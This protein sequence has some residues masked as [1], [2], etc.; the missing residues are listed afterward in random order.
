MKDAKLSSRTARAALP[1]SAT[2]YYRAIDPGLHLGYRQSRTGGKWLVRWYTGD[3]KYK[4]ETIGTADDHVD[5]D[6]ELVLDFRQAQAKARAVHDE[7]VGRGKVAGPYTV[8]T[9]VDEYLSW[10]ARERKTERDSRSRAE[11]LILPELGEVECAKLTKKILEDWLHSVADAA[12]R[13][14]TKKGKEQQFRE[15]D[16]SSETKRRRRSTA[17]RTLTILKAALNHGWRDGRIATDEAWRRVRPFAGVDAARIRYLTVKEA[18][19]LLNGCDPDFRKMVR[20]ALMTGCRYGELAALDV[21][22]FHPDAGTVHVRMSKSGKP[23]HVV[24]NDDGVVFFKALVAGR[25]GAAPMFEKPG[26]GRWGRSHQDRPMRDA[27]AR[28]KISP[29]ATFHT[30]R[31]S[32]ASLSIMAGA[33]LMV[34]A[35]NLGHAD[36]RMVERHYGHLADSFV[37]DTIRATAPRFGDGEPSNVVEMDRG[38]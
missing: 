4:V 37:A 3:G 30:L 31:H 10:M 15:V 36:T 24:L 2:P 28:A 19:R 38:T 17:N 16:D 11:A 34:V 9:A 5:P 32:W 12:P 14:R 25:V 6:G 1:R 33:P 22:D 20:G 27:C 7:A 29:A 18:Q 13:L 8:R 35:Q 26:G 21:H 23:R